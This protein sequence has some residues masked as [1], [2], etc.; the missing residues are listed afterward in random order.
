[1]SESFAELFEESL[2]QAEM[3][4]GS[5]LYGTVVDIG[6]D[7]VVVNAG[8][9][10]E[11]VIPKWQFLNAEGLLEVQIGDQVEVALDMLEGE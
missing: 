3:R 9:K 7:V 11:G 2:A 6:Q 1:M 10:S 4:P 5:V 8:L